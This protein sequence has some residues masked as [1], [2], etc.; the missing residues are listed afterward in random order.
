MTAS[1]AQ[2]QTILI[3]R[4]GSLGDT[5]VALPCFHLIARA[6]PHARRVLLTNFPVNAKAPAAASILDNSGLVQDYMS[7]KVGTRRPAELLALAREIRRLSPALLIYLMPVRSSRHVRRD[8][9]FFRFAGV[10]Q[11]V[12]IPG[13]PDAQPLYEPASGLYEAEA[14]RLARTLAGL[15]PADLDDP[16]NWS[17]CLAAPEREAAARALGPL[18]DR[19]LIVCGPGTKMQSKDWGRE[20]W[21]SLL[22][23]LCSRH[24][25]HGLALVGAGEESELADSVACQWTHPKVNLCG[26]LTPR[27]TAAV[28]E[29]ADLFLGPDSGP[30]HLAASVGVPCAIAFSAR[31]LPGV[32]FP[33]GTRHQVVYRQTS[34]HGCQLETCTAQARRCLTSITVEAMLAA[35][36]RAMAHRP[37]IRPAAAYSVKLEEKD[38]A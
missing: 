32:W 31:S 16:A 24:P 27:Q 1:H 19:P 33:A 5:V 14:S 35:S 11:I 4:L 28:L 13:D 18:A 20:N 7:Y 15:G 2:P 26:R 38:L 12:G 34:C 23:S 22:A 10:R 21:Q 9:L 36:D 8:R 29:H 17:L 3:Y 25:A 6:F 37:Q 30:M